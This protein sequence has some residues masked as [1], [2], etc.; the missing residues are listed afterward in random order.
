MV[1]YLWPA[2]DFPDSI[3]KLQGSH[4]ASALDFLNTF[5]TQ[6]PE[7]VLKLSY[8][9]PTRYGADGIAKDAQRP[10]Q[11]GLWGLG[12]TALALPWDNSESW[13]HG[14]AGARFGC[15]LSHVASRSQASLE[16]R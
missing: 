5:P 8:R 2:K 12:T 4:K 3:V 11:R 10:V 1:A 6:G 14:T 9:T 13:E 15:W 16:K 7:E